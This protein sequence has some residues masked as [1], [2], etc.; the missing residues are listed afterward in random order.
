MGLTV[1]ARALVTPPL[2]VVRHGMRL[3]QLPSVE[4]VYSQGPA[5]QFRVVSELANYLADSLSNAGTVRAVP[6]MA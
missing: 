1:L 2:R 3:P 4:L 6:I 5:Q